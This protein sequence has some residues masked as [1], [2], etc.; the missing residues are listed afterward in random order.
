MG[1]AP[2]VA[3]NGLAVLDSL[4]RKNYGLIFM[5]VQ[6]PEMD[7]L[8]ATRRIRLENVHQPVIVAMTANAMPEDRS[9]C[10]VAGMDDYLGKPINLDEIL[11][12]IERWWKQTQVY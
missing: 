4:A 11:S 12:A 8:E 7:G 2:D 3:P 1:Y 10:L 6:M 5:D 9:A